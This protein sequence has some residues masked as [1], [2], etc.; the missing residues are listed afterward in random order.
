MSQSLAELNY[1]HVSLR[2]TPYLAH[3]EDHFGSFELACHRGI[4]CQKSPRIHSTN[5][6][7]TFQ[8][9]TPCL[10]RDEITHRFPLAS[11]GS[12]ATAGETWPAVAVDSACAQAP[13]KPIQHRR[14]VLSE[15]RQTQDSFRTH[16]LVRRQ[17][18]E[19]NPLGA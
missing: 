16:P 3:F 5:F 9:Q 15:Y 12:A 4:D 10:P 2:E 11:A 14:G 6:E 17:V 13:K 1:L 19:E 18:G 8:R 7:Q